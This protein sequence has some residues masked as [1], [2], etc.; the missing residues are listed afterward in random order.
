M[1]EHR[2]VR[3]AKRPVKVVLPAVAVLAASLLAGCG[4]A[5]EV[6]PEVTASAIAPVARVELKLEKIAPGSRTGEQIY[7]SVCT[8]CHAAGALG[9]PKTG[10]A[11]DW[12]GRLSKGLEALAASV[13]NGLG[14]MPPKGGA[15]DLTD[16]EI[17]RAVAYLANTAG[18]NFTEPPVE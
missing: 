18:A 6:D 16:K 4:K 2:V 7:K 10:E 13:T 14:N 9:A 5:P 1:S 12:A 17:L 11:G 15:A 3:A 8:S